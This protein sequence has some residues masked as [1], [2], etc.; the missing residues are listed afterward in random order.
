MPHRSVPR[1]GLQVLVWLLTLAAG[2]GLARADDPQAPSVGTLPVSGEPIGKS[3][4]RRHVGSRLHWDPAFNR[5]DL[6]E[7]V[8]TGAAAF[9]ALGTNIASPRNTGWRGGI[10]IDDQVRNALRLSTLDARLQI[11]GVTD[12][13]LAVMATFPILVDSVIVAYWYRGSDDVALQMVLIDAEAFAIVGALAGTANYFSGRERPYGQD[14]GGQVPNS[15]VD[16][17]FDTRYRSFFSGHSAISF[18][19]A[20]LICAHHQ[21]LQLFESAADPITCATGFV[22]AATVG[23]L[24]IVGDAH[25]LS[26]VVVG[27]AVGTLV[28][29]GIP[30][31]HHYK[32][33]APDR[34]AE[35]LRVRLVPALT[36]VQL[37]GTF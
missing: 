29:L 16:C 28:G 17:T 20:S 14:C 27:A 6:P 8:V 33:S 34:T 19:A 9:V 13:G 24:R 18:T 22:A 3:L 5:M 21:A 23:A 1:R 10:L 12:V 32:R 2:Q 4:P 37:V 11:R 26:D 31:L 35:G 30:L 25:Y 7:M 15:S 36:G